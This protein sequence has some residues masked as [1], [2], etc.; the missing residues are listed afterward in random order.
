MVGNH[1]YGI[2]HFEGGVFGG[3]AKVAVLFVQLE[4]L[5]MGSFDYQPVPGR[6]TCPQRVA[7]KGFRPGVENDLSRNC[8]GDYGCHHPSRAIIE[9]TGTLMI[10]VHII[11]HVG[12]GPN[13]G[14]VFDTVGKRRRRG[15]AAG[16]DFQ[17]DFLT[18][19]RLAGLLQ[20]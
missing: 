20:L 19:K 9:P 5:G 16:N 12:P 18:A 10:G 4:K 7:G 2:T 1:R 3:E 15:R 17:R 14:Q 13:L 6:R 11:E 8:G